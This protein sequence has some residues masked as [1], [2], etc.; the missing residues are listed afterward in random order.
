[1]SKSDRKRGAKMFNHKRT[2]L[3]TIAVIALVLIVILCRSWWNAQRKVINEGDFIC[4]SKSIVY[5]EPM[6]VKLRGTFVLNLKSDRIAIHYEVEQADRKKKLFFQD[7]HISK[8]LRTGV[9]TFTFK[10]SSVN[11][12]PADTTGDMFSWLRLLQPGTVNELN[13]V[14]IGQNAYMYSLNRHLYNVCT[15]STVDTQ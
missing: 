2:V 8:L 13:I 12:F 9:R 5:I 10:V 11:K 14:Q 15:T 7:I 1:M 3:I 4:T 6:K